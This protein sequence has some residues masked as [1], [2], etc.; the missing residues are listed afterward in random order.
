MFIISKTFDKLNIY[1]EKAMAY[2]T[3]MTLF[4]WDEETLAPKEASKYTA[5]ILGI[6]ADSYFNSLINE[7]V[8]TLLRKLQDEELDSLTYK[9]QKIVNEL[10]QDYEQLEAI[11]PNEYREFNELLAVSGSIW[12][13]A[14]ADNSFEDFAPTLDKIIEYQKKFATY[15]AEKLNEP[16]SLYEIVLSDYEKDLSIDKLDEFFNTI[17]SDIVPLFKKV[18]EKS[19]KVN[20]DYNFLSYDINKQRKF[21]KFISKYI[22]FDYDRGVIAESTHPFT[23][24]LHNHDVRITTHYLKN[25]LESSIFSTIH[26]CGHAIYEMNIADELTQTL[27]GGG[28]SMGMHESQSRFFENIM[29]RSKA[30]WEPIYQKLIDTFPQQLQNVSLDNFIIGINKVEPSLIRTEADEL[31]YSLHV[32]IRYEIEK[33]IFNNEVSVDELPK[34]WN[35]KYEEYLGIRP[36]DDTT[37]I[38][39]DTHWAMGSFGYFP[40]YAIGSAIASQIYY[41]IIT[42]MPFEDNLKS[43]NL[44]PITEFL[45]EHIHRFG[46]TKKTDEFL[47]DMMNEK[48]NPIYY[49]KYLTEKYTTLYDL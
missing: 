49:T 41:H 1:L 37:G 8:K 4:Q 19:S 13:K 11:P 26:E 48:F 21:S 28:A 39:Q 15:R 36:Q 43:M 7:D 2:E 17:K 32:L 30:F 16:K 5:K 6:L 27:V 3:A 10:I 40:S 9:E 45:K 12:A 20:K 14:K 34:L 24:N 22:G 18:S 38:L 44:S 31:S 47:M 23:T 33:M 46:K 29:G 35:D 42:V 25:N